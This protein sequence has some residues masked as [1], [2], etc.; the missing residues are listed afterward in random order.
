MGLKHLT[1]MA[2]AKTSGARTAFALLCA[3]AVCCSVM[4]ITSDGET[5]LEDAPHST[6][7]GQDTF[8][9][10]SVESVDV[11]KA[12]ILYTKT[13]DTLKKGKEGRERLLTFLDKIEANIAKEVESRKADITAIRAQMAKN[14]E[15]NA[16]ARKKM[17][18][19]L[20]AKMA[21]N[22]K[23]AADN[24]H[25]AMRL[26]QRKFAKAAALEN[27]RNKE[28]IARSM[29]TREIMAKN[30]AEGAKELKEAV[31][32][33]QRALATLDSATNAKIKKTNAH[34]A[35]NAAQ[36]KINAKKARS[37]LD[38][39]MNAFDN[40]MANI[41]AEAKKGR[42]KLAAQANAMDKKFRNWANNKIKEVTAQTA[43]EFHDVRA[44][45]A[46][47]RAHADA[48][49]AHAS[50]R[51]NAAL[52]AAKL[53]QNKRFA[54]SVE[55]IAAA[56]KEANDRVAKF[57]TSFKTGILKLSGVVAHQTQKLNT[58][59]TQLSAQI[60]NNKLEQAKVNA[61]VDKEVKNMVKIGNDR[62]AA[63]LKKDKELKALMEKN[64]E[65]T[66]KAMDSMALK[67]YAAIDAIKAQMKKDRASAEAGLSRE[68]GALYD[69]LKKNKM[70]Q[71]K[72]NK[73]LTEA[74]RRA[75]LDAEAALK[76]AK[77]GFTEKVAGLHKTVDN[78]AQKHNAKIMKLTG[79]VA[80]NAIK[81]AAGRAELRK[82]SAFN[83]S[84]LK[85]AVRDAIHK[86]EQRALQIEKKMKAVNKKTRADLNMRIDNEI[87]KLSKSIHS[88]INELNLETK[89]AR[90]QMKKEILYAVDS[91]AKLAKENLKKVVEWAEGE[92]S[93]LNT[94]LKAEKTKSEGER[95]ALAASIAKEKKHAIGQINNAVAAQNKALLALTQ[96]TQQQIKKTNKNLAAAADQMIKNAKKVRAE[97]KANTAAINSSLEAARKSAAAELAAVSA[98]SAARYNAVVKAV[99]DG[100]DEA[101]KLA[102]KKFSGVYI[103]MAEDRKHF[104][105]G[106]AGAV[107]DLN[108]KI[109]A[110]SALEDAR[111]SKTVKNL[112]AARAEAAKAVA[113]ARKEMT[114]G[115]AAATAMIKKVE[116]R[117]N[118]DI[119][120]VSAMV[121]SDTA[122]QNRINKHVT[123][124]IGRLVKFS[125]KAARGV[126]RKIMDE[127]KA[128]AAEEVANLAKEANAEI[129]KARS[130]QA[131]YLLGF[132]KDLT[133][134]TE[135]L[136]GKLAKDS[137]AQQEALSSL[138]GSL[139]TAK[140]DAAAGLKE[141]KAVFASRVDSLTN[142]ITANAKSFERG[143]ER[144]TGVVME[145]KT[146]AS[147][148]RAAI[149]T[150][151]K[152]MVADLDKNIVRAI[153]LGEAKAKA[154]Q[155][156]SMENI[157]T[158]KKALLTTI[159]SSVENMADNVF[160]A[161]Q[162]GRHKI[163]DNFLSLKAYATT[164]ADKITDY[165]AKGKGRNLASIGD[166]L[167]TVAV[168]NV[169]VTPAQG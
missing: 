147:K 64:K 126:I 70:A 107:T 140:A 139:A 33:Q 15:Y 157:A 37:A 130:K 21:V 9:P 75:K 127:N 84:L 133:E 132:K 129:K 154:V 30:K 112:K 76:E 25:H 5:A 161:V 54:Q 77:A 143:L 167:Q 35:A 152:A 36:I 81:D 22:A 148:D 159:S 123:A 55:D 90:A 162:E 68:T 134:A 6:G 122:A 66:E 136:Y 41:E 106:L 105:E 28:T 69:T 27:K 114:S 168:E 61:A 34:I 118:G 40:K 46:K 31:E 111:F 7:S 120:D 89:E 10:R 24:L 125:D 100:V 121:I 11:Q 119:Q 79:V 128:A 13:P 160:K 39:A 151:R 138:K 49:L 12:G 74:T 18:K 1:E 92:F 32:N 155:E 116:T 53:L 95:A 44:T 16:D 141:A 59:V 94:G 86:G 145:W 23:I 135:D 93:K 29:K 17:K 115:I 73:E 42:S 85:N 153:Q 124:E 2:G 56:K 43:K 88:Q 150:L 51:M 102:D 67:F 80:Q 62:Y 101:R 47:D 131:A 52:N 57:R 19:M 164:A 163:A 71:D 142:A 98:A 48:A 169:K 63:H 3:L 96:E 45:M 60:T 146:S 99:E 72:A 4:Y 58:R 156:R 144:A 110:Q 50:S 149:R 137:A 78:L 20:L 109:A 83:K 97:M 14:M 103:K 87:S 82:I 91:E 108:D 117:L 65:A 113:S 158:E 38:H 104:D 26:T 166:L 165:L 8:K